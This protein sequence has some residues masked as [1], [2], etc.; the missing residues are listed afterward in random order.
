[1]IRLVNKEGQ[2]PRI[3][4]EYEIPIPTELTPSKNGKTFVLSSSW[5]DSEEVKLTIGDKEH[6][7]AVHRMVVAKVPKPKKESF[8]VKVAA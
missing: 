3:R 7:V 4:V 8:G 1:M 2:P 6:I 5:E